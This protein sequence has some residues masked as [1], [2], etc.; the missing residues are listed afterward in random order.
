MARITRML[1]M[2]LNFFNFCSGERL[3]RSSTASVEIDVDVVASQ[4]R[5]KEASNP[6]N[7]VGVDVDV[8]A[9]RQTRL[10]RFQPA[11][12]PLDAG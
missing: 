3:S 12:E 7:G 6:A 1:S 4:R 8:D 9:E 2:N 10:P 11:F 5:R